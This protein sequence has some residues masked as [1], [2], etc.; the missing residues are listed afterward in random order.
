MKEINYR[1]ISKILAGNPESIRSNRT[2]ERYKEAI[3]ELE[4][5]VEYWINKHKPNGKS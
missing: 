2:P 4:T 5:M 1:E 3:K